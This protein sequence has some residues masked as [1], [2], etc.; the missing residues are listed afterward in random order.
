MNQYEVG[1]LVGAAVK[2][3]AVTSKSTFRCVSL[4]FMAPFR[5][6]VAPSASWR[7]SS[8]HKTQIT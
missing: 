4:P 1:E 2:R 7:V 8:E 5:P 6:A 3:G